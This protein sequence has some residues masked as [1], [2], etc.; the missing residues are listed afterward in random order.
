MEDWRRTHEWGALTRAEIA[1]AR[2]G[3]ALPVLTVGS[4]EQH[5]DHLPVDTDSVSAFRI[6]LDAAA[7]CTGVHTLVLPPPN[8]GFSPHHQAWP[9]TI[10]LKLATF[11]ALVTDV[12]ESVQRCGFDRLLVVN[13]HGGN[14]GPLVAL[15]TDLASRGLRV[16]AI[17]Y[18]APSQAT[19]SKLMRGEKPGVGHACEYETAVQLALRPEERERIAAR[20][21]Q[22][23]PR[24]VPAYLEGGDNPLKDT[25][26]TYAALFPA[27]DAGYY[28]DPAAATLETGA[29]LLDATV[30][31][32][33]GF[34][35]AFAAARLKVA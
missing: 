8:F 35:A 32:L 12:A 31:G 24:L 29:A 23:P 3:G 17:S 21:A 11:L 33:A 2:D 27:G 6:A 7:R 15:C 5:G 9:G 19:W 20:I 26:V 34:Y 28:G 18:F 22:L 16:A 14:N 13:G 10:T 30:E 4:C 25:G 1:A